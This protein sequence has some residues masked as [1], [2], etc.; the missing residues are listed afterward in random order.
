MS[1]LSMKNASGSAV[2]DLEINDAWLEREK[3]EQAV[4]DTVVAYLAGRR[5]GTASTKTRGN[6]SGG[7]A[8]PFKQ[9]G[10]GRARAGSSRS[11]VWRGGGTT[12]G[13]LPRCYGKKVNKKIRRLAL[14]R[15]FTERLDDGSMIAVDAAPALASVSTK[16]L[17]GWLNAVGAGEH[18]L[19]LVK[20][21]SEALLLSARNL[22]KV[23][24]SAADKVG[25]YQ[26]LLYRKIVVTPDAITALGERLG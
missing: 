15:A 17:V 9:K 10:T 14:R 21:P 24:V 22:P 1:A 16:S 8:K 25:V 11:P 19:I 2:G 13:P 20:E 26:L 7:G 18:V 23:L 3:G 5:A 6:V 4:Q 12:F